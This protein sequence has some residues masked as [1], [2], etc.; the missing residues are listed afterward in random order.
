M[1]L[2]AAISL[3]LAVRATAQITLTGTKSVTSTGADYATGTD[4]TYATYESISTRSTSTTYGTLFS[5][6]TTM[7]SNATE[8][9]TN[10]TLSSATRTLLVGSGASTTSTT[11]NGTNPRNSTATSTSTSATP[12]NTQPCN[13]HPE[14]CN[15]KFSNITYV[16]A[17]NS[18]FIRAGNAASNQMLPV[19]TQLE[20]G[21][22]MRKS[23][24]SI[25]KSLLTE[26]Q[27]SFRPTLSTKP[28]TSVTPLARSSTWALSNPISRK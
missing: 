3:L 22:R 13:G 21:I 17:H 18:P 23:D 26:T 14:F 19:T 11:L 20:D 6:S 8:T 7:T 4:L 28:F 12:T 25:T 2:S 1:L 16:A 10:N 9:G 5:D 24:T 27:S 15:R